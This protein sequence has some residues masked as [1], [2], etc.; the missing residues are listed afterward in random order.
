MTVGAGED[1]HYEDRQMYCWVLSKASFEA[2]IRSCSEQAA[3]EGVVITTNP[4]VNAANPEASGVVGSDNHEIGVGTEKKNIILKFK[5]KIKYI[6]K[7]K[8]LPKFRKGNSK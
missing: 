6:F 4:L 8:I 1:T 3:A 5:D 2:K 7:D